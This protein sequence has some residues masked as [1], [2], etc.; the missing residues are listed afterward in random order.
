MGMTFE[1]KEVDTS[2][3]KTYEDLPE[4]MFRMLDDNRLSI[5]Y[6]FGAFSIFFGHQKII[7]GNTIQRQK[8]KIFL[9]LPNVKITIEEL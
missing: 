2:K 8:D 6:K 4:G 9:P 1:F 3:E 7:L 5:G